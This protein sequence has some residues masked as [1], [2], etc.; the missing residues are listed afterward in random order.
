MYVETMVCQCGRNFEVYQCDD[1]ASGR[2][3]SRPGLGRLGVHHTV[4]SSAGAGLEVRR[5]ARRR[6]PVSRG[7]SVHFSWGLHRRR[8]DASHVAVMTVAAVI[9]GSG[10][11]VH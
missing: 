3:A 4:A 1:A 10:D 5:D 8:R 6:I 11:D 7:P 2:R 9:D